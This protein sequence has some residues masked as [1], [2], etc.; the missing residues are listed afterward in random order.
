MVGCK[1]RVFQSL[2]PPLSHSG[3][4][5][6][7]PSLSMDLTFNS[8]TTSRVVTV[9]TS[10][11]SVIEDEE[12]FTLIL[13]ENDDA[14]DVMPQSAT[15]TITDK[16]SKYIHCHINRIEEYVAA[17]RNLIYCFFS[18][19]LTFGFDPSVYSVM[20]GESEVVT[21]TVMGGGTLE[22][23]VVV[24]VTSHDGTAKGKGGICRT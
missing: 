11:D 23:D 1:A 17:R 13:T 10:N 7:Y 20:E 3:S 19:A 14:V 9:T 8:V 16:T 24:T 15:V 6:D 5:G 4:G 18:S 2:P 21:V 12:T 22:R